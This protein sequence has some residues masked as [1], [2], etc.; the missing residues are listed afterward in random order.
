MIINKFLGKWHEIATIPQSFQIGMEKVTADYSLNEDKTIKIINSGYLNGEFKQITG[1]AIL[2][3]KDDLLKVSFF[4]NVYA[5]YKILAVSLDINRNVE[6]EEW[7]YDY[8]LVGGSTPDSLWILGR[9]NKINK[10]LFDK[11]VDLANK[12][13]YNSD[14]LQISK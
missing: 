8:A 14:K 6:P 10:T 3:D 9:T 4:P 11:F 13:G 12:K 7:P 2:T 5:D 1:T